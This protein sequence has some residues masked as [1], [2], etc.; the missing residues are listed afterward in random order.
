[1]NAPAT[2]AGTVE[3][4]AMESTFIPANV[5]VDG[6][7]WRVKTTSTNAKAGLVWMVIAR[8]GSAFIFAHAILGGLASIVIL[9]IQSPINLSACLQNL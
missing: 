3:P 4:V 5:L 1:M 9:V 8:T 7:A 2:P 6:Q